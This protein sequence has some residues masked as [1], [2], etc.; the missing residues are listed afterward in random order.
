MVV[1]ASNPDATISEAS[2]PTVTVVG[3]GPVNQTP[4]VLSGAAQ[5]ASTLTASPGVWGGL[6]NTYTYQWQRSPDGTTWSDIT[7]QTFSSYVIGTADEANAVRVLV[8]AT[9]GDGVAA[10]ASASTAT[11]PSAAPAN[12]AAPTVAGAAVRATML[13]SGPGTWTGIGN[14]YTYQWQRSSDASTW[15]NIAGETAWIYTL[16]TADE[17]AQVRV[18]VTATNPDGT[19]TVP[20][21]PTATVQAS[22]P[23]NT[24]APTIAGSAQRGITLTGTQGVWDGIGNTYAYQWQRSSASGWSDIGGAT[25]RSTRLPSPT[26]DTRCASR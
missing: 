12:T 16:T 7:G 9:N 14:A 10:A 21:A 3:A 23:S 13:T 8:T 17:G 2:Q 26:K 20:S 24:T 1:T 11:I 6:G 25:A 19:L 22:A 15:T 18:L 5:R 4:P